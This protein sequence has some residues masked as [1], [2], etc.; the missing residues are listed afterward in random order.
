VDQVG[1]PQAARGFAPGAGD[2][3][4]SDAFPVP[5]AIHTLAGTL[6]VAAGNGTLNQYVERRFDAR[7]RPTARRPL[8]SGRL[9]LRRLSGLGLGFRPRAASIS[10]CA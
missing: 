4:R 3:R 10:H 2:R 8:A 6:L 5:L 9:S 1:G 7:M